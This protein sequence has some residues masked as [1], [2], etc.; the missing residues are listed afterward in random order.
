MNF[1]NR[2]K[3]E[4]RQLP[5]LPKWL[6]VTAV[7]LVLLTIFSFIYSNNQKAKRSPTS[8]TTTTSSAETESST[9]RPAPR[10][11]Q[12]EASTLADIVSALEGG[13]V[14]SL[15]IRG[16][17]LIATREDGSVITAR[18]ESSISAIEALR[19]LGATDEALADLPIVVEENGINWWL[20]I[21]I[22]SFI[23]L[24]LFRSMRQG[25]ASAPSGLSNI[26]RSNPRVISMMPQSTKRIKI[27]WSTAPR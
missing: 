20:P 19:L 25:Q 27:T 4:K 1:D 5:L 10:D 26:G 12:V 9:D 13:R 11:N 2:P 3:Q 17:Y 21:L 8:Y 23:G 14:E 15:T 22:A 6:V 7:V 16:D 18:K 24:L